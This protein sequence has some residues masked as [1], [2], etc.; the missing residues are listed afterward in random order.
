MKLLKT[1]ALGALLASGAALS[2]QAEGLTIGVMLLNGDTYFSNVARGVEATNSDGQTIV[3]NY[4][5]DAAK[6]AKG[7]DDLI[8]RQVDAII[9]S[10]LNP[11]SSVPALERATEAGIDVI[12]YN[13]CINEQDMESIVEAFI[14][15]DQAG[16]GRET[17]K[18]AVDYITDNMGGSVTMGILTCDSFEICRQRRDAFFGELEAAGIVVDLVADQEAY[19]VDKSVPIAEDI[20]TANPNI[21]ALW[22]ANDG[23]T[24]GLVKAVETAGQQGNIPVF[25]TDMTP[26]LGQMLL[27]D[28]AVVLV[29]TGQDGVATGRISVEVANRLAAGETIEEKIHMVPVANYSIND[30]PTVEAYLEVNQ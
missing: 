25:G 13:T 10:P 8:T 15:S 20:L 28:P 17:G 19:V 11:D 7:I 12:C 27:D 1:T 23:G 29:T 5:G 3:V 2:V 21:T 14:L 6:E 4:N 30:R 24:V 26:Q 22:A 9:T 18:F 16:L